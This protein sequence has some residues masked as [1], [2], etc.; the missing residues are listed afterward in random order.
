MPDQHDTPPLRWM[1]GRVRVPVR[2]LTVRPL[3]PG[4]GRGDYTAIKPR[5]W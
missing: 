4:T 2:P 3:V 5:S 1:A